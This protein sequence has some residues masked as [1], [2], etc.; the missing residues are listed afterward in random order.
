MEDMGMCF[1]TAQEPLFLYQAWQGVHWPRQVPQHYDPWQ[2]VERLEGNE[3][4]GAG[5]SSIKN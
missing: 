4:C 3:Q 2:L 5:V 1:H